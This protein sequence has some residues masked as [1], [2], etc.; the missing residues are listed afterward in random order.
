M[1]IKARMAEIAKDTDVMPSTIAMEAAKAHTIA[2]WELGMPPVATKMR[3][4]SCFFCIT[5]TT[6]LID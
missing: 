3:T 1:M 6:T 5:S 4:S 2:E